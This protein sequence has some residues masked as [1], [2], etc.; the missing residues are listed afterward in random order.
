MTTSDGHIEQA[1]EAARREGYSQGLADAKQKFL[2]IAADEINELVNKLWI[3]HERLLQQWADELGRTLH[4]AIPGRDVS[5]F[6]NSGHP[7]RDQ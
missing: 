2:L 3:A 1:I 5:P 7:A 6:K 4:T